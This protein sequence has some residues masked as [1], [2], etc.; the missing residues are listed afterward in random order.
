MKRSMLIMTLGMLGVMMLA[1]TAASASRY[2]DGGGYDGDGSYRGDQPRR[3]VSYINPD[4]GVA[5]ENPDVND[6]SNC[7]TLDR[8]AVQK[9]S[10]PGMA[11]NDV[12]NDA[13]FFEGYRSSGAV[14]QVD[15]RP[16]SDIDAPA[17]FDSFGVGSI[18]A[19]PDPDGAGPKVARLSDRNGDGRMDRCFQS[20]Y[21]DKGQLGVSDVAGDLEFHART[22]NDSAAGRQTVVWGYDPQA[23]GLSD[24]DVKDTIKIDWIR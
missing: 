7:N 19:C 9:L 12:H 23:N 14:S 13:C 5:T 15:G 3:A 17:T 16:V 4:N 18:S 8:Y 11:N 2:Y 10:N 22:N 20:G 1:T 21:Q 6:N 24:T